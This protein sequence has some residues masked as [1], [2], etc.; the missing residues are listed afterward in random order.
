MNYFHFVAEEIRAG[1]ASLGMRSLDELTGRSD[2]LKQRDISLAKTTGLDLSFISRFVGPC[3]KYADRMDAQVRSQSALYVETTTK[4]IVLKQACYRS[5]IIL[6][7][8]CK[9][10]E[11]CRICTS[12]AC[13]ALISLFV[14]I[15]VCLCLVEHCCD[16]CCFWTGSQQWPCNG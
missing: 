16:I 10:T 8:L 13:L 14:C 5:K 1:L 12:I 15:S 4:F 6:V 7:D 9:A 2:L 3:Q 11:H